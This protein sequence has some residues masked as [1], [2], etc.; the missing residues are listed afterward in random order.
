[1]DDDIVPHR[2]RATAG[3]SAL[4]ATALLVLSFG[5]SAL[6]VTPSPQTAPTVRAAISA[7]APVT[8]APEMPRRTDEDDPTAR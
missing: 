2:S 3:A 4:G 6:A 7:P 5:P 8:A 1:M